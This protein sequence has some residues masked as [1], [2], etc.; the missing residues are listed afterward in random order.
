MCQAVARVFAR[1]GERENR[2]KARIKFL[3]KKLGL[4]EFKRLVFEER[5]K[6]RTDERWT[7]FLKELHATDDRR[8]SRRAS[9]VP[10]PSR[11]ASMPGPD[12]RLAAEPIRLLDGEDQPA[13]RRL[14]AA[15]GP[16]HRQ[17]DAQYTGDTLR[18]TVD[19][20]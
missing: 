17:H 6:L 18:T 15:A 19:Q 16:R 20:T 4:E 1:L 7:A 2:S 14:L 13:A 8:S 12:Q 10:A 5:T 3:V 11:P 9:S